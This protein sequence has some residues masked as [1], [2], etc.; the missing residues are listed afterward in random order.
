MIRGS[1]QGLGYQALLADLGVNVPLRVWT[2]S[3]AAIGICSRQGLGKLRHLDTHTLWIQQAV[4]SRR[5]DLRKVPGESNP[6]DLLT[7]HSLSRQRIE[8]L[9]ALFG[10]RYTDGRAASAPQVKKGQSQRV[11]MA[12]AVSMDIASTVLQAAEG[13][14]SPYMPHTQCP[15]SAL[16]SSYPPIEAPADDK[17]DDLE[18][19]SQDTVLQRGIAT[20]R[21][22]REDT[23]KHGRVRKEPVI[24]KPREVP[25]QQRKKSGKVRPGPDDVK[26]AARAATTSPACRRRSAKA[27]CL[28]L[29]CQCCHNHNHDHDNHHDQCYSLFFALAPKLDSVV[30]P[31]S[32]SFASA[33]PKG[34]FGTCGSSQSDH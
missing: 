32:N 4:R 9:V 12:D 6:A 16:D 27:S 19:D 1:G 3:S 7:K 25:G 17:L 11:S 22:I 20:A 31:V 34:M 30:S 33:C 21:Q 23:A 24:P 2:D 29:R 10:C 14:T 15:A 5:I 28:H 18:N 8:E 26:A 13:E